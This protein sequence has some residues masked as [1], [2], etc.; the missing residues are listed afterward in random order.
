VRVRRWVQQPPTGQ[1][2][3]LNAVAR[4]RI[5]LLAHPLRVDD[6]T[7]MLDPD[8]PDASGGA[9]RGE[10]LTCRVSGQRALGGMLAGSVS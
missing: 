7:M 8:R 5:G 10:K 1:A 4:E 3:P 6:I 2:V 9:R